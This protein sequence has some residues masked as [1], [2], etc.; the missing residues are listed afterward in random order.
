MLQKV[1]EI[2]FPLS[3][4]LELEKDFNRTETFLEIYPTLTNI[5]TLFISQ[6]T[7]IQLLFSVIIIMYNP[8]V[9]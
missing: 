4:L 5:R 2:L 9:K 6:Y 3:S 8:I 1:T 7:H